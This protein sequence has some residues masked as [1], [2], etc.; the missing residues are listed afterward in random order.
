MCNISL[1][2]A[3]ASE[4]ALVHRAS[5]GGNRGAA[6]R[7]RHGFEGSRFPAKFPCPQQRRAHRLVSLAIAGD[8]EDQVDDCARGDR[9]RTRN[10]VEVDA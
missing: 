3:H 4:T 1:G 2:D 6:N 5:G 9:E 7:A 10:V 8:I